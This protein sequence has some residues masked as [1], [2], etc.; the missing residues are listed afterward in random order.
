MNFFTNP[1]HQKAPGRQFIKKKVIPTS[2][3]I[4]RENVI[5]VVVLFGSQESWIILLDIS[6]YLTSMA[7]L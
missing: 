1:T 3:L 5:A 4:I 6:I 2:S 7:G